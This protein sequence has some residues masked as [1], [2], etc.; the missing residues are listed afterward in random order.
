MNQDRLKNY[1]LI[2]EM[3]ASFATVVLLSV[4]TWQVFVANKTF[5]LQS[6]SLDAQIWQSIGQQMEEINKLFIEH[7]DLY[8]Y[9][10]E[11]K[12][13]HPNDQNYPKVVS[14]AD[15]LLDFIDGFEDDYVRELAGME[16]NG[17]YWIAWENYFVDQFRLSPILCVRYKEVKS[18][19]TEN[20]IVSEL[21]EKGCRQTEQK[22]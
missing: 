8:P 9:F 13:I 19:Y 11:K 16:D 3:L 10:Y 1:K 17:E 6:R 18:W 20:G 5:H 22:E 14:M 15:M 21:A 7:P 12:P 2:L 4:I